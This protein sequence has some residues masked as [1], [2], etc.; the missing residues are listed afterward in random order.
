VSGKIEPGD[1][2]ARRRGEAKRG[3]K[4][5]RDDSSVGFRVPASPLLILT[6]PPGAGK[7]TLGRLVASHFSPSIVLDADWFWNSMVR[8]LIPP[9]EPASNEQNRTLTR[10]SLAA[11]TRLANGGF[12][13]VLEGHFGP[14]HVEILREELSRTDTPAAYVILRPPLEECLRRANERRR[15]PQHRDALHDEGVIRGLYAQ[16]EAPGPFEGHVLSATGTLDDTVTSI[17]EILQAP[18]AYTL[19]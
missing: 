6:G 2:L 10:A 13:T 16:Y 11:T 7:T 18:G 14:W 9:W 3:G 12:T 15:E 19:F 8:G 17:V 5:V 4:E 1:D